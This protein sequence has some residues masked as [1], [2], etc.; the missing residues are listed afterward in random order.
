MRAWQLAT[1][2]TAPASEHASHAGCRGPT[3]APHLQ[4]LVALLGCCL[5]H[6]LCLAELLL[7]GIH[8]TAD[9]RQ[10]GKAIGQ[11]CSS[12]KVVLA[13]GGQDTLVVGDEVKIILG[14]CTHRGSKHTSIHMWRSSECRCAA[15]ELSAHCDTTGRPP[16]RADASK[17]WPVC[18]KR[19]VKQPSRC[20][21]RQQHAPRGSGAYSDIVVT[22]QLFCEASTELAH[23]LM[24]QHHVLHYRWPHLIGQLRRGQEGAGNTLQGL[25]VAP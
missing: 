4:E 5:D 8:L 3:R 2:L 12:V 18:W 20:A 11:A 25:Q 1:G 17:L 22:P 6:N 19:S 13:L 23:A 10:L 16:H 7:Q 9:L 21:Q 15:A 14:L 24:H